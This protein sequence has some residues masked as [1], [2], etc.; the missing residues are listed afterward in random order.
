MDDGGVQEI[1]VIPL[2]A[3]II[4]WIFSGVITIMGII[5]FIIGSWSLGSSMLKEINTFGMLE[6]LI[7]LGMGFLIMLSSLLFAT[8]FVLIL[9]RLVKWKWL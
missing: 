5:I 6:S 2:W 9:K 1:K 8:L 7:T 3:R 4:S